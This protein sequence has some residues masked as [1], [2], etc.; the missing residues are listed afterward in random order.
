METV[1][2]LSK[3]IDSSAC[4]ALKQTITLETRDGAALALSRVLLLAK[5]RL[6]FR[7]TEAIL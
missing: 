4:I 3:E 5:K 7:A 6:T 2:L 1:D